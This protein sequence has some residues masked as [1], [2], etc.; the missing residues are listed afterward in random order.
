MVIGSLRKTAQHGAGK[1]SR[2]SPG[3]VPHLNPSV[4]L[5]P[6]VFNRPAQVERKIFRVSPYA[7]HCLALDIAVSW[8]VLLGVSSSE[9][10]LS[11]D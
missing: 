6:K 9:S 5:F 2:I 3:T 8:A 10:T 4:S 1:G 11:A 7:I